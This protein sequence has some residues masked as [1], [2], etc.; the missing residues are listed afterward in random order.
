MA[1]L[2]LKTKLLIL[3]VAG[4]LA[5]AGAL[6]WR[7]SLVDQQRQETLGGCRALRNEVLT[8]KQKEFDPGVAELRQLRL[9]EAQA[10][11]L[12]QADVNAYSKFA[13]QYEAKVVSVAEALDRLNALLGKLQQ[14]NCFE[15][16]P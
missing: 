12:R 11:L 7:Q 5:T 15:M 14:K 16:K 10:R 1:P 6:T 3:L 2:S 9:N 4:A 13:Q 8:V